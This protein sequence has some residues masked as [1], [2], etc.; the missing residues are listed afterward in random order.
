MDMKNKTGALPH[1]DIKMARKESAAGIKQ[2]R[3]IK[4]VPLVAE[5]IM[6]SPLITV[7]I[8]ES[9]TSAAGIMVREKI[10]GLAVVGNGVMGILTGENIVK[11]ILKM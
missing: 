9:A 2:N 3:Y 5:D 11:S 8:D 10:N 1:K 4:E 7:N 6:S